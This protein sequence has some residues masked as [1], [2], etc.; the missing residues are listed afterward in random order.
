MTRE[1]VA[2]AMSGGVDSSLAAA[3]L[4]EQGFDVIGVT[5][6]TAPDDAAVHDPAPAARRAA[7][8][9]GIPHHLLDLREPFDRLVVEPFCTAYAAGRTPNPC[10]RCNRL[11]KFGE[12]LQRAEHLGAS[13][14]ATGHY[15]RVR[16]DEHRRRWSLLAG[17][18]NTKDQSYSLYALTQEQ[19][20]R[21]IFPLGEMRKSEVRR[22]AGQLQLPAAGTA[23]SQEICFIGGKG[24][25]DYLVRRRPEVA[26]PGPIVDRRGRQLG[27][28]RGIAFHTIGQRAGL[29]ISA[30]EPFY[31]VDIDVERNRLIVGP[32]R[33]VASPGVLVGDV[34]YV[35]RA[36][37]PP[38]GAPLH[39]KIRSTTPLAGCLARPER[40]RVRIDFTHP[41]RAVSPGQAAVCYE[42][43]A[44]AL[45]GSIETSA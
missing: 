8:A 28:H 20:A 18:D 43:E 33:D 40:N 14:F 17:V 29:R 19:L 31:V 23:E 22:R 10:V 13:R 38:E 3:L 45:G 7:D 37:L 35:S 32:E 4:I 24:Y 26:R 39:I 12:L 2:V 21:A 36:S 30:R 9:L 1:R 25:R 42:G 11:V 16:W 41:Q 44:V 5:M 34:N 15:A 6:R 27:R